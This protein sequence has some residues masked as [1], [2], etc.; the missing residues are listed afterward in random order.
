MLVDSRYALIRVGFQQLA[1]DELL[2]GEHDAIFAADTDGRAAVL[3]C[4]DCVLDLE[5]AAI[6][7]EDG[8]GEIVARAYRGLWLRHALVLL[9]M[10]LGLEDENVCTMAVD[11]LGSAL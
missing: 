10:L 7:G 8:V 5:V 9:L 2:H 6:G 11:V 1:C 3:D 4:L